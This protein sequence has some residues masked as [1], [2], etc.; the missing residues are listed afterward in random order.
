MSSPIKT[1]DDI[2]DDD[3]QSVA[4][5]LFDSEVYDDLSTP[6]QVIEEVHNLNRRAK[7]LTDSMVVLVQNEKTSKTPSSRLQLRS[8]NE[9]YRTILKLRIAMNEHIMGK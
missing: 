4:G 1:R 8:L 7:E 6:D 2:E 5:S 3:R 9:E